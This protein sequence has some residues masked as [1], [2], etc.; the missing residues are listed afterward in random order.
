M[1]LSILGPVSLVGGQDYN[2]VYLDRPDNDCNCYAVNTG[3]PIVLVDCGC[4]ES[5]PGI[6]QNMREMGWDPGDVSHV[7]L[8]H[9]HIPHAGAAEDLRRM[10]VEVVGSA[11]A[12]AL[13]REAA[14]ETVAYEYE[15]RPCPVE[16]VTAVQDGDE[17]EFGRMVFRV[18]ETPGHGGGGVCYE[19]TAADRRILFT[20]DTVRS[21]LLPGRRNRLDYDAEAYRDSLLRLLED[22]PEALMPG[23]GPFCLAKAHHWI[24]HELSRLLAAGG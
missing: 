17:L 19:I 9:A 10:G 7:L 5:L 4:G 16:Q 2:V 13:L 20:G 12:A 23:H 22:P 6:L 18:V 1:V 3:D 21:P 14:P 11:R 8:T 24:G 15:R